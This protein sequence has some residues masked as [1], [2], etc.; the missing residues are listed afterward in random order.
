[1]AP[2]DAANKAVTWSSSN[3]AVATVNNGTIT[4]VAAGS[5][6]I[7]VTTT[8]GGKTATCAVT[9]T[10]VTIESI[11]I[12]TPPTRV[13]YLVG[14]AALDLAGLV[15][16]A[17]YNNGT[18]APVTVTAANITGYNAATVG[19]QTLTVTVDSKT[20]TFKV[21]VL[22][23][24]AN[25]ITAAAGKTETITLYFDESLAP[26]TLSTAN[27]D[28]TLVGDGAERTITLSANG[29]LFTIS[30]VKL[31]LGGKVTLKGKTDNTDAL[32]YA[33]N[34][35]LTMKADSKITGN[36]SSN[37]ILGAGGVLLYSST[38]TMEGGTITGNHKTASPYSAG[39]VYVANSS[40]FNMTGGE[41]SGNSGTGTTST[42]GGVFITG[43]SYITKTGGV[44]AGVAADGY[45]DNQALGTAA[46]KGNAVLYVGTAG[47]KKVDGDVTGNLS[48]DDLNTGWD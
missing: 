15:V 43:T 34:V 45:S 39:G 32:I 2:A 40:K 17:T 1:V 48:T 5:A 25:R 3:A 30:G 38:F 28:I 41:I 22:N 16:T 12:T 35:V 46:D 18:T 36:T 27:T 37:P 8:D 26:T 47:V 9:V 29:P 20:A 24:L 11:A 13:Y 42:T 33:D 6:V 10:A 4:A 31:T 21:T 23:T 14:T 19:E 44:I 7:A